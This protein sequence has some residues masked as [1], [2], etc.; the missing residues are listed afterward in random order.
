MT[1]AMEAAGAKTNAVQI[2]SDH[3]FTDHRMALAAT[4]TDWLAS[5][6]IKR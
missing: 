2:D 3:S 4:V 5:L 1:E 6:P